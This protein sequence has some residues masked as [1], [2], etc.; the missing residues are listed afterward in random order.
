MQ[1]SSFEEF[2]AVFH[3][4]PVCK[5][6]TEKLLLVDQGDGDTFMSYTLKAD[7]F[8]Y[9]PDEIS[10]FAHYSSLSKEEMKFLIKT[11]A[12]YHDHFLEIKCRNNH[13]YNVNSNYRNESYF[14]MSSIYDSRYIKYYHTL[15]ETTNKDYILISTPGRP[16]LKFNY[17]LGTFDLSDEHRL[18][19][20]VEKLYLLRQ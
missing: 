8:E 12:N 10:N 3:L 14:Y 16:S 4:C 20:Q 1:Y 11:D 7:S 2:F 6:E 13:S 19:T 17:P 5:I 15:L 18:A 9:K